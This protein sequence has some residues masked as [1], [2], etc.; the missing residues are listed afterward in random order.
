MGARAK[1][2]AD[3]DKVRR[4]EYCFSLSL[5]PSLEKE[6]GE[7]RRERRWQRQHRRET[8]K[9]GG[10]FQNFPRWHGGCPQELM[11]ESFQN[12]KQHK[13]GVVTPPLFFGGGIFGLSA[14]LFEGMGGRKFGLQLP[15]SGLKQKRGGVVAPLLFWW[16]SG[17]RGHPC[18]TF[19]FFKRISA[20]RFKQQPTTP[21]LFKINLFSGSASISKPQC[22]EWAEHVKPQALTS[23]NNTG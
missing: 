18:L 19:C 5:S 13:R 10:P 3:R 16:L 20:S 4:A 22:L 6:K 7:K 21:V 11:A 1:T 17:L 8:S 9:G 12:T 2:E 14:P 15:E 23:Q